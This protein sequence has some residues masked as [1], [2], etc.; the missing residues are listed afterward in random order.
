VSGPRCDAACP[1]AALVTV[2][3]PG[4]SELTFCGHHYQDYE[5]LLNLGGWTV[6]SDGRV[7]LAA[8]EAMR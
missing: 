4:N 2:R 3:K 6:V 7:R 1:A 5:V 8:Q